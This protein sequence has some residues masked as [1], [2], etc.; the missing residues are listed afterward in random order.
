MGKVSF[1]FRTDVHVA[2]KGPASWKGD[3]SEEIWSN[4]EQVGYFAR[5]HKAHAVLDGGDYFHVKT[6]SR[7]S[8]SL[9][10]RTAEIH[11]SYPCPTY[12]VEGNHDIT[13]NNLGSIER[14]PLGVLYAAG[15]FHHLRDTVF[16]SDG[17]K[18]RVVGV[19]YDPKQTLDNLL[20]IQKR[21][22]D[23]YLVA[24]VHAWA[25]ENPP[26]KVEEFFGEPVFKYRDLVTPDGPDAFLFGHWHKD[27]GVVQI[28]GTQFVNHGALSRGALTHENMSRIPK[29]SLLEF[30]SEGLKVTLLPM[31]V[32]PA[33]EVFDV[34]QKER[35]ETEGKSIDAFV[36]RLQAD[37]QF[38]SEGDITA[39]LSKL[40][41]ASEVR[42]LAL[43]YLEKVRQ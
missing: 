21:P 36:E 18:V 14:Q 22:E 16:E 7:N 40:D 38:D 34:E 26:A 25:G 39:N 24:V 37:V 5:K 31:K 27:Q 35:V 12:C 41:F 1:I 33:E 9:I 11:K 15:V 28:K 4:L 23:D 6:A 30:T 29:A 13:Y 10:Y 8:H 3:Y 20:S 43:G 19:P 2:D 17:L 42:D 32:L